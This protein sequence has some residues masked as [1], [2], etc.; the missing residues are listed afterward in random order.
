MTVVGMLNKTEQVLVERLKASGDLTDA[1][2][3]PVRD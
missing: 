3:S 1:G 2:V